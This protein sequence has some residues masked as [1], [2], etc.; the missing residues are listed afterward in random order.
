MGIGRI[1]RD[2]YEIDVE[3]EDYIH[4]RN[5]EWIDLEPWDVYDTKGK[6]QYSAIYPVKP[7][8]NVKNETD[9]N[10]IRRRIQNSQQ[11]KNE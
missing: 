5:V 3:G 10:T 9:L 6:T 2:Y 4:R 7:V 8:K 11:H 1:I